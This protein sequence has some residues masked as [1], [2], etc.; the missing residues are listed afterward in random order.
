MSKYERVKTELETNGTSQMTVF[1]SSMLPII[2]SGS[3]L[4]F[5]PRDEYKKGDIVFCR[6]LGRYIDSHLVKRVSKGKGYLISNNH[7]FDNGW[8][9][10][11][12]GKVVKIEYKGNTKNL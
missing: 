3:R 10:T 7:G 6:V 12:Y 8:T 2:K 11:I 5:E 4:T 9:R 1:G